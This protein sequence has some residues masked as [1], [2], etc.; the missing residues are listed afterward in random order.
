MLIYLWNKNY[1]FNLLPVAGGKVLAFHPGSNPAQA[2]ASFHYVT[3]HSLKLHPMQLALAAKNIW[4]QLFNSWWVRKKYHI[5]YSFTLSLSAYFQLY[6]YITLFKFLLNSS[7]HYH[8]SIFFISVKNYTQDFH[9]CQIVCRFPWLFN[10]FISSG[11]FM[12]C[13]FY[14]IIHVMKYGLLK[15]TELIFPYL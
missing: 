5:H 9:L 4:I 10:F 14:R 13:S 7:V 1:I 3:V 6:A 2:V 15:Q 8:R 12:V 11:K